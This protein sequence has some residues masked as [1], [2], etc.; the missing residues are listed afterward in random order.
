MGRYGVGLLESDEAYELRAAVLRFAGLGP[1]EVDELDPDEVGAA[2]TK[3]MPALVQLLQFKDY[4]DDSEAAETLADGEPDK[5]VYAV[6]VSLV[7]DY[8]CTLSPADHAALAAG[9]AELPLLADLE[10]VKA[11]RVTAPDEVDDAEEDEYELLSDEVENMRQL[12]A[13]FDDLVPR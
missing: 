12:A 5:T 4:D 3:A 2:L 7:L 11:A 10:S 13:D 8:S 9:L 6:I 1:D